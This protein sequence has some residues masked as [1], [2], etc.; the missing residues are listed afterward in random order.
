MYLNETM[1]YLQMNAGT[2]TINGDVGFR[3]QAKA[4]P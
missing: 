2:W 1:L 3:M 4:M